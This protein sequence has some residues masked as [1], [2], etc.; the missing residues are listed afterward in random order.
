M[1]GFVSR[2]RL[3]LL[4][5]NMSEALIVAANDSPQPWKDVADYQCDGTADHVQI[6]QAIQDAKTLIGR[7]ILAPTIVGYSTTAP[8]DVVGRVQ[9][10]GGAGWGRTIIKAAAGHSAIGDADSGV[11]IF[12]DPAS[13]PYD[14]AS[15]RDV[16]IHGGSL[17]LNGFRSKLIQT[18]AAKDD[19]NLGGSPDTQF[20]MEY[21]Q[22][23][24]CG[25]N[26]VFIDFGVGSAS[27]S[28]HID[29]CYVFACGDL[30]ST[31][32]GFNLAGTDCWISNCNVG[33][34]GDSAST[35]NFGFLLAGS[36]N[37][38]SNIIAWV[39]KGTG[40]KVTGAK[41]TITNAIAHH[42]QQDGFE[43][44][45]N[46]NQLVGCI[47]YNNARDGFRV[48]ANNV[49]LIGF[50]S[51]DDNDS[52]TVTGRPQDTGI[53]LTQSNPSG[54]HIMGNTFGSSL[55]SVSGAGITGGTNNYIDVLHTG[56][57]QDGSAGTKLHTWVKNSRTQN[58]PWSGSGSPESVVT[59]SVGQLWVRTDGGAGTTLYVKESGTG[60]TGWMAK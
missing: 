57:N 50:Q 3:L 23:V 22:V 5:S 42:C 49:S 26:G 12:S 60:N 25:K 19:D 40:I 39:T 33:T 58:P 6:N 44:T 38:A 16:V 56:D 15:L 17:N 4:G 35:T 21:V 31:S 52:F 32:A 28:W 13:H 1:P 30:D 45:N 8:V 24:N 43:I 37:Q 29:H 55:T 54:H 7:V 36:D 34:Q 18:S 41:W 27:T 53:N 47:G 2:T 14:N 48:S 11:V 46:R 10:V 9:L 59:A 51:F 20:T